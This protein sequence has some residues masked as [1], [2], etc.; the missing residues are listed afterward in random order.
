MLKSLKMKE[1]KLQGL[2][3]IVTIFLKK[4]IRKKNIYIRVE[5][6]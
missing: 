5:E 1:F 3:Y 2:Q 6:Q 4:K